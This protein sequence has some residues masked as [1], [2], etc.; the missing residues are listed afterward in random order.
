[1]PESR[2]SLLSSLAA[3]ALGQMLNDP[4][5]AIG[6]WSWHPDGSIAATRVTPVKVRCA[7]RGDWTV[8]ID[9]QLIEELS[10]IRAN[11]LPLETGG[12]LLGMVDAEAHSIHIVEALTAPADSVEESSGFERGMAG[13][14]TDI[15]N[16]MI[17]T[18]DQVRYVGEWHS[19]PPR[20][21]VQPSNIDLTQIGWLATLC[22]WSRAIIAGSNR[23][24]FN[25]LVCAGE[26]LRVMTAS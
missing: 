16:A 12:V 7:Q 11:S 21:S 4:S 24:P 9:E 20:Y 1:M 19:H 18:M 13:L 25:H 17:R 3:E 5:A 8:S 26:Q 2:A 23:W 14:E 6:V 10:A 15:R 22:E